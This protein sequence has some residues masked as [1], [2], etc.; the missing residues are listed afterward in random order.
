MEYGY[1]LDVAKLMREHND[2]NII[3]FGQ[4]YMNLDEVLER[5]D[6]FLKTSFIGSYHKERI[7]LITKLENR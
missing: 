4:S 3:A 6:M 2:A 7:D 5:I 1:N